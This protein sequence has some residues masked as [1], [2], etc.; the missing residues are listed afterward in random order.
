MEKYYLAISNVSADY[1]MPTASI[2]STGQ[3]Y[4]SNSSNYNT[5]YQHYA[6][7]NPY[8]Y[9]LSDGE[10]SY[11]IPDSF[12]SN[13]VTIYYNP[14]WTL[15]YAS[16]GHSSG[17]EY[18]SNGSYMPFVTFSGVSGIG[19]ITMTFIEPITIGQP[20]GTMSIGVKTSVAIGAGFT[21]YVNNNMHWEEISKG[22][23]STVNPSG[24]EYIVGS[25]VTILGYGIG[26]LPLYN[27]TFTPTTYNYFLQ[28][29]INFSEILISNYGQDM[30]QVY[31]T[32]ETSGTTQAQAEVSAYGSGGSSTNMYLP[33][34]NYN[35]TY[36]IL[37]ETT[38]KVI[39]VVKVNPEFFNGLG[40]I[41]INGITIFQLSNQVTGFN[42]T[43]L[44]QFS[45]LNIAISLND[46]QIKN[47][48]VNL[49]LNITG[50][51][52]SLN[53]SITSSFNIV[54]SIL[55]DS[56]I[57]QTDRFNILNA[58][59][60]H[61]AFNQTQYFNLLNTTMKYV[62][63]SQT[64]YFQIIHSVVTNM[65]INQTQRYKIEEEAGIFSYKFVPV[66]S[67][68]LANGIQV[69]D[70]IENHAGQVV[71]NASLVYG[72]WKNLSIE[73]INLTQNYGIKPKLISY[74]NSS[75]TI[76]IPL[77]A[78]QLASLQSGNGGAEL[79]LASPFAIGSFSNLATG[80]LN[81]SNTNFAHVNGIWLELGYTTN[82]PYGSGIVS[83]AIWFFASEFGRAMEIMI[84]IISGLIAIA[85]A[86]RD[87]NKPMD[88]RK[89][90]RN[91]QALSNQIQDLNRKIE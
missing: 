55:R 82:P 30:V 4:Q 68:L 88:N 5:T 24:F 67:T 17:K 64:Q 46:T 65:N 63:L 15:E 22:Q 76:F 71:N 29:N 39:N 38:H 12:N 74:T 83:L 31:A 66:N 45:N 59:L 32:N 80:S 2:S 13:Y 19:T 3:V 37:N 21:Y 36:D 57:N 81:P 61:V 89:L 20:L 9:N 52:G 34:G 85:L 23:S 44:Q 27:H 73:Y 43:T 91:L 84:F 90:Q 50:L 51:N 56:N 14:A 35:F 6:T 18:F 1:T 16:Y 42:Q 40:W 70:N 60:S 87:R 53:A 41:N 86:L 77:N 28:A 10:Y 47:L 8:Q 49:S 78:T 58:S 33:S 11:S 69:T 54:D 25:P 79:S 26:N 48:E 72:L 75:I 7:F 62:N